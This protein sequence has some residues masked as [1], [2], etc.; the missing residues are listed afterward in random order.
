MATAGWLLVMS[1]RC[2]SHG[3]WSY[4]NFSSEVLNRT[5]SQMWGRWYL[6][7]FLLRDGL[8]TLMYN[9][10][11]I[12]LLR[13]WSSLPTILKLSMVTLVTTV[14]TMV[15]DWGACLLMFSE[16]LS[17]CSWGFTYVFLITV[18][19]AMPISTDDHTLLEDWILILWGHQED[20]DGITSF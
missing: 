5:S 2:Y 20:F 3:S 4:F 15:I 18:N 13:F 19:P 1:G 11:F 12:A 16:P 6:S 17:K 7:M 10:S 8:L 9:A 14:V